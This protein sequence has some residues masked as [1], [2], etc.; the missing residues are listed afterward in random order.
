MN[1]ITKLSFDGLKKAR[2]DYKATVTSELDRFRESTQKIQ[3]KY[4]PEVADQKMTIARN[5]ARLSINAAESTFIEAIRETIND[6]SSNLGKYLLTAPSATFVEMVRLYRDFSLVPT[7]SE[8]EALIQRAGG[9]NLGLRLLDDM[10]VKNHA[11]YRIRHT[12]VRDY[13]ADIAALEELAKGGYMWCPEDRL[14]EY[15]AIY[16]SVPKTKVFVEGSPRH[17]GLGGVELDNQAERNKKQIEFIIAAADCRKKFDAIDDMAD[18][19]TTTI[20]PTVFKAELYPNAEDT[21]DAARQFVHDHEETVKT[22]GRIERTPASLDVAASIAAAEKTKLE[23]NRAVMK[24]YA[25]GR[26]V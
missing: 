25:G 5:S 24:K 22:S 16:N 7:Q 18:R 14:G 11:Q 2:D 23:T 4:L 26:E 3:E 15:N 9:N 19:W 8:V 1:A 17:G 20:P 21:V 13:E 10:L 12:E 6:L